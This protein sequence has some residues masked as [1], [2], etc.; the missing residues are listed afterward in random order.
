MKRSNEKTADGVMSPH[1]GSPHKGQTRPMRNVRVSR[2][3]RATL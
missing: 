2:C 3:P 1:K